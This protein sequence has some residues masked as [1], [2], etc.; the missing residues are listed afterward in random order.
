MSGYAELIGLSA[1]LIC[2]P[3][4]SLPCGFTREGLPVGLQL[5]AAPNGEARV[6]AGARLLEPMLDLDTASPVKPGGATTGKAKM[7]RDD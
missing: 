6:L 5:V 3:A 1:V 7:D 2:S 4:L